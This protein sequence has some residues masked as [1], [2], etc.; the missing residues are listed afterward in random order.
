MAVAGIVAGISAVIAAVSSAKK[1]IDY[2]VDTSGVSGV[3]SSLNNDFSIPTSSGSGST[4]NEDNSQ[5][6]IEINMTPTGN[7][8]YDA[9]ELANAVIKK[10]VVAKQSSGR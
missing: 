9:E 3:E 4:Y 2:D 7:L 8:D 5:Y 10:I 1:E 6:N